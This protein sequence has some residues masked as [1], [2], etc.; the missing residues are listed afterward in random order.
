MFKNLIRLRLLDFFELTAATAGALYIYQT[1]RW[2]SFEKPWLISACSVAALAIWLITR[3]RKSP[4][5]PGLFLAAYAGALVGLSD[6]SPWMVIFG[7]MTLIETALKLFPESWPTGGWQGRC[8]TVALIGLLM[9][10]PALFFGSVWTSLVCLVQ[11][12]RKKWEW[13][14][15]IASRAAVI[16]QWLIAAIFVAGVSYYALRPQLRHVRTFRLPYTSLT[17]ASSPSE[18][19][20]PNDFPIVKDWVIAH[21]GKLLVLYSDFTLRRIDLEGK[22]EIETRQ[23]EDRLGV[24]SKLAHDGNPLSFRIWQ[25]APNILL[26]YAFGHSPYEP[27]NHSLQVYDP[28][29]DQDPLSSRPFAP[30]EILVD[31]SEN[32][33]FVITMS[34]ESANE[35]WVDL[36]VYDSATGQRIR[37]VSRRKKSLERSHNH[38]TEVD[39]ALLAWEVARHCHHPDQWPVP[40]LRSRFAWSSGVP[41]IGNQS[42]SDLTF[43]G[44]E[45]STS[46]TSSDGAFRLSDKGLKAASGEENLLAKVWKER[47]VVI[48]EPKSNRALVLGERD[49]YAFSHHFL[50]M[51][52]SNLPIVEHLLHNALSSQ[53]TL[54]DAKTRAYSTSWLRSDLIRCGDEFKNPQFT[55]DGRY[56]VVHNRDRSADLFH[57]F[58]MP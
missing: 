51:P 30:G 56:L 44:A 14:T 6:M 52:A 15:S 17:S 13:P 54:F 24:R 11:V 12:V 36:A 39:R 29:A 2:L 46:Q 41:S 19:N 50:E 55:P 5:V 42:S 27:R 40:G 8:M 48:L 35:A 1:G 49:L 21:D 57:V 20:Q 37:Q 10:L 18:S 47:I 31:V 34:S 4:P 58:T 28:T 9:A 3:L 32:G 22:A 43:I 23:L 26:V 53:P 25:V 33:K 45:S 16:A 7:R 38:L